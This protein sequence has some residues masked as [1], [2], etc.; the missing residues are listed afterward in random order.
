MQCNHRH[1]IVLEYITTFQRKILTGCHLYHVSQDVAAPQFQSWQPLDTSLS[2]GQFLRQP[3][4]SF[5][6]P[7][8]P[9]PVQKFPHPFCHGSYLQSCKWSLNNASL[10]NKTNSKIHF[11]HPMLKMVLH[12]GTCKILLLNAS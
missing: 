10:A 7:S 11:E 12:L 2:H 4:P 8:T 6:C 1:Y 9:R 3:F 5:L